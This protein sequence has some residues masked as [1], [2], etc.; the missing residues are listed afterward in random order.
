MD[1]MSTATVVAIVVVLMLL[2]LGIVI[3]QLLRLRKYLN[4]SPPGH[5]PGADVGE[6]PER[7]LPE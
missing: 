5:L 3:N 2:G 6:P 7:D 4:E 1:P